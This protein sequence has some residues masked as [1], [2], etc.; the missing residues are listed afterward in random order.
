MQI[1]V[2]TNSLHN[3]GQNEPA[4]SDSLL[5]SR[6]VLVLRLVLFSY[7]SLCTDGRCGG[8]MLEEAICSSET[9]G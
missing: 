5:G 6:N 3:E 7:H 9:V 4:C 8:D 1:L 2:R